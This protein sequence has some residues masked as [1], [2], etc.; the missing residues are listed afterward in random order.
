MTRPFKRVMQFAERS[1]SGTIMQMST[2]TTAAVLHAL[3]CWMLNAIF[4]LLGALNALVLLLSL[5]GR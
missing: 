2:T 3:Q 5:G 4:W 1:A